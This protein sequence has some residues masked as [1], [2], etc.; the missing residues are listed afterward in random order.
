MKTSRA[1]P[2]RFSGFQAGPVV[3]SVLVESLL[4]A[5]LGGALGGGLAWLTVNGYQTATIN[6]QTFSQVAFRLTVTPSLLTG[7]IVYAL[8]MGFVG[9]VFPA[10]RAARVKVLKAIHQA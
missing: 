9:G 2:D 5:V 4:L 8:V 1:E 3:L 7:G 6:W 10:I